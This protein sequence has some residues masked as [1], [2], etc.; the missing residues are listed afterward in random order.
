[1]EGRLPLGEFTCPIQ[2]GRVRPSKPVLREENG[3]TYVVQRPR[4]LHR[5]KGRETDGIQ[6][7]RICPG[8]GQAPVNDASILAAAVKRRRQALAL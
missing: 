5:P 8:S 2:F 1:M 6:G 3:I 4:L 7:R